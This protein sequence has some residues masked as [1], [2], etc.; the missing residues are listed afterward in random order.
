MISDVIKRA[1]VIVKNE[2][3]KDRV[4]AGNA[5]D[6]EVAKVKKLEQ[7]AIDRVSSSEVKTVSQKDNEACQNCTD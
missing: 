3:L 6:R 5:N 1:Q 4:Q 7:E 2:Q